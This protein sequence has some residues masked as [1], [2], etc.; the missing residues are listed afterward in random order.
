MKYKVGDKVKVRSDLKWD[1]C[2]GIYEWTSEMDEFLGKEYAITVVGDD[3]Y[4]FE[5]LDNYWRL[6]DEM[7]KSLVST[8]TI[9]RDRDF[10]QLDGKISSFDK[11]DTKF[12]LVGNQIIIY[13]SNEGYDRKS[14]TNYRDIMEVRLS[15]YAS[16]DLIVTILAQYGFEV[17]IEDRKKIKTMKEFYSFMQKHLL[18]W[19]GLTIFNVNGERKTV[20]TVEEDYNVDL[21]AVVRCV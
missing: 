1:E 9:V 20:L 14:D 5:G 4:N 18:T 19:D 12:T 6:T 7:I 11:Y 15:K 17:E 2:Y 3:Y 8:V 13:I 16:A 21:S 10:S